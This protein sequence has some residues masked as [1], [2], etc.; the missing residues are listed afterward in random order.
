VWNTSSPRPGLDRDRLERCNDP[1]YVRSS[2]VEVLVLEAH[3]H[4][5][6]FF[7]VY[8]NDM[9]DCRI[10]VFSAASQNVYLLPHVYWNTIQH[11]ALKLH[12]DLHSRMISVAC[13][14]PSIASPE[15][16]VLLCRS[17]MRTHL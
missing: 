10:L 6:V 5:D 17:A 7:S 13:S 3:R 12:V 16:L 8:L 4:L 14:T 15:A 11:Q 9:T 2:F 1:S